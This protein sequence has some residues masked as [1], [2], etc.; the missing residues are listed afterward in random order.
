MAARNDNQP[1][2]AVDVLLARGL[3]P[4]ARIRPR[5]LEKLGHRGT[6][7]LETLKQERNRSPSTLAIL[8]R[9]D[10]DLPS[11]GAVY[12]LFRERVAPS[13][14]ASDLLT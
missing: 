7:R 9:G 1:A 14:A 13:L 2:L 6:T 11:G 10:L 12:A 8:N 4:L 3:H 5:L